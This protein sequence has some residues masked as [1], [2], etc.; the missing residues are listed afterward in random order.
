MQKF[1]ANQLDRQLRQALPE[2]LQPMLNSYQDVL[3]AQQ[4]SELEA[5]FLSALAL[6]KSL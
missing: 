4:E 5:M 1:N 2:D 6:A 3:Y